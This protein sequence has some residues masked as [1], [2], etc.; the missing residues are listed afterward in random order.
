MNNNLKL[1]KLFDYF[2]TELAVICNWF[3]LLRTKKMLTINILTI[4]SY[5]LPTLI[6]IVG[7]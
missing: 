6:I 5:Y 3:K 7:K 2:I 4:P 1:T